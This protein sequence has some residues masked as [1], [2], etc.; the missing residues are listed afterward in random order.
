MTTLIASTP[1][2]PNFTAFGYCRGKKK[3]DVHKWEIPEG[4]INDGAERIEYM[5]NLVAL[6][7]EQEIKKNFK[8]PVLICISNNLPAELLI[9]TP[10]LTSDKPFSKQPTPQDPSRA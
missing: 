4:S 5:L 6:Q 10:G 2:V 3:G 1:L 9:I 8:P 7:A